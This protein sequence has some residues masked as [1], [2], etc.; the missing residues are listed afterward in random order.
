MATVNS[1]NVGLSG[2]S[3]SGSFAGT[4]SPAFTT[5][6][7]GVCTATSINKVAITAPAS[8]ATLTIANGGTLA[9]SGAFSC[10]LTVTGATNVTLPTSG[11]L[12][13]TG[14]VITANNV[15]GTSATMAASNLYVANNAGLVTLT[16]PSTASVGDTIWVVGAGAG[17][18]RIA[19]NTS[20]KLHVGSTASTVTS[21]TVS[22]SNQYD[23]CILTC[24]VAN[25]EWALYGI[26]SSGLT[27]T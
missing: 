4:T 1:V 11:T 22:S 20:G 19:V 10:T 13:T 27:V 15:T 9:T 25:N 5:P 26:Q 23:C 24:V 8:S 6:D 18:W 12:A 17:G 7:V 14:Q 2:S 21:G 3:G 16:V